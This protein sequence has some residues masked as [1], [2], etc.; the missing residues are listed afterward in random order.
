M[1]SMAVTGIMAVTLGTL[2]TSVRQTQQFTGGQSDALQHARVV[3]DRIERLVNE[4]RTTETYPGVVA[5]DETVGSYR[6]PDTLVVWRPTGAPQNPSGP[7]LVKELVIICPNPS[8]S[9]ELVEITALNDT[10]TVALNDAGLNTTAGRTL[11]SG[12][13]TAASST[14]TSLT[15]LLRSAAAS[16][17][18]NGTRGC[19]RFECELHPTASELNTFRSSGGNWNNLTW[20]QSLRSSTFGMRQVWLRT[21]LQ[22]LSE[23]RN[24]DGSVPDTASTLPFYGSSAVYYSITK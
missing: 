24:S 8:N 4:A 15:P 7:P 21:E 5:V 11:I 9:G 14:K 1:V 12:I 16:S 6:F 23:P 22:L 2:A 13:K 18:A 17:S 20:A 3:L 10:R 19:V